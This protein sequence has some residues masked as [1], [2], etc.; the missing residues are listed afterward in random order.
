MGFLKHISTSHE[1]NSFDAAPSKEKKK[2]KTWV[3]V[4]HVPET[5][6]CC[7]H[8]EWETSRVWLGGKKKGGPGSVRPPLWLGGQTWLQTQVQIL[9]FVKITFKSFEQV[10]IQTRVNRPSDPREG[11]VASSKLL[12]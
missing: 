8:R 3:T 12:K 7:D 2:K 11:P 9:G 4:S 1:T 6:Q 5:G 10:K